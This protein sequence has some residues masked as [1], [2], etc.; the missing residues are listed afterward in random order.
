[1]AI[2]HFDLYRLSDPEEL[3]YL[4]YRDYLNTQTVC[5][6]EWPERVEGYLSAVGLKIHIE[7]AG[8]CRHLSFKSGNEWGDRVI[9]KLNLE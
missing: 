4:G 2:A 3:E 7:Y 5:F 1:M 6:I 9:T 8:N